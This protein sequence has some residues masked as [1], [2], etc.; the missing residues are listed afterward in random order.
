MGR[1]ETRASDDEGVRRE[2]V[3]GRQKKVR[4]YCVRERRRQQILFPMAT[5]ENNIYKR[6]NA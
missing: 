2:K 6:Y 3:K 4:A 5:N 1:G